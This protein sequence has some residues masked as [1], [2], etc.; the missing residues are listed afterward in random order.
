MKRLEAW[1]KAATQVF[2]DPIAGGRRIHTKCAFLSTNVIDA[3]EG[4]QIGRHTHDF[5]ELVHPLTG[6]YSCKLNNVSLTLTPGQTLM[7]RPGDVHEDTTPASCS[8]V[9]IKFVLLGLRRSSEQ[10]ELFGKGTLPSELIFSD[11]AKLIAAY[12]ERAAK[13]VEKPNSVTPFLL[14]SWTI[15]LFW[16]LL[17]ALPRP[18][19]STAVAEARRM[20][21]VED[22]LLELFQ[23]RIDQHLSVE[24]M[25]HHLGMSVSSLERACR[26]ELHVSAARAFTRFKMEEALD[27]LKSTR[28]PLR[29]ISEGL[30]FQ[31]ANHFST[32]FSR[33]FGKPPSSFR[34]PS[35]VSF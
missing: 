7:V 25:A 18:V 20:N 2:E 22:R 30:G 12:Q 14:D 21:N 4:W 6:N 16:E 17:Q 1:G 34:E 27:L 13:A 24:Q 10:V 26:K 8:F 35:D 33:Y 23:R 28:T 5:F 11:T 31:N 15:T 9:A 29:V 3:P 32:V 19:F